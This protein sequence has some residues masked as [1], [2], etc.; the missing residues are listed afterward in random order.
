MAS[1]VVVADLH[2]NTAK[3]PEFE[4]TRIDKLISTITDVTAKMDITHIILAGDTFDRNSPS[5][6]D[7]KLFYDLIDNLKV[8]GII[9]IIDGNHDWETFKFLP[10]SGFTYYSEV[11][12][13]GNFI[14]I[15]WAKIK[16]LPEISGDKSLL[17]I[18]HARCTVEP[19]IKEEVAIKEYSEKFHT[20]ILGDIHA[21]I[22]PYENVWYCSSPFSTHYK[23]YKG[24][25]HGFIIVDNDTYE[26]SRKWI[27]GPS[28]VKAVTDMDNLAVTTLACNNPA[29]LYKIV[30]EDYAEKLK[31]INKKPK[32]N[33]IVEPLVKVQS[34]QVNTKVQEILS[35]SKS[36][37]DIVFQY[38]EENYS[39]YD[40]GI[41][42]TIK[43]KIKGN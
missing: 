42:L 40:E 24:Y 5:L 14:F 30:V 4:Q 31:S 22:K 34:S 29:N 11:T 28:K 18:S 6:R 37:E 38:V 2:I 9:E 43:N 15:P 26:I 21:P 27:S 16:T 19:H 36:I 7:I 3:Y 13:R 33:I 25:S 23:Q 35:Q 1:S 17:C 8:L 10:H 32:S 39:A 20:T 41:A 12:V